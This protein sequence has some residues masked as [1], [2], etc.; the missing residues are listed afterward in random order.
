M[1]VV[2][3]R[4]RGCRV[5]VRREAAILLWGK[6]RKVRNVPPRGGQGVGGGGVGLRPADTWTR[7]CAPF[8]GA[9]GGSLLPWLWALLPG[10]ATGTWERRQGGGGRCWGRGAGALPAAR[11]SPSNN[12]G[13]ARPLLP[14]TSVPGAPW[15]AQPGG[16]GRSGF[17][18]A[19]FREVSTAA[20][21]AGRRGGEGAARGAA[22]VWSALRRRR[23]PFRT[24]RA[25]GASSRAL[26]RARGLASAGP[27]RV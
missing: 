12:K 11:G 3:S 26:L 21:Y 2:Q 7:H 27:A 10:T 17:P 13:A 15:R 6:L 25:R 20:R 24:A 1:A 14:P 5:A 19:E 18:S 16:A 9:A 8:S 23:F 22:R 4:S